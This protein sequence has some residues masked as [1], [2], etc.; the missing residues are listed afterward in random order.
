MEKLAAENPG[1]A[2]LEKENL[3]GDLRAA[4]DRIEEATPKF[5][6]ALRRVEMEYGRDPGVRQALDEMEAVLNSPPR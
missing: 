5:V 1:L 3:P 6:D 4:L 2:H